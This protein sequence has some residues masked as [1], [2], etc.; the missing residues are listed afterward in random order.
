M[1]GLSIIL[2]QAL[3]PHLDSIISNTQ[4]GFL[5]GQS[6]GES[7]RLIHDLLYCSEKNNILGLLMAIDFDKAFASIS[8]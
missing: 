2:A 1:F 7:T 5:K 6:I 3:K 4:T 8:W